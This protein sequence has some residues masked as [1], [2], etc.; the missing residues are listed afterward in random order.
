MQNQWRY[1]QVQNRG[2]IGIYLIFPYDSVVWFYLVT[3]KKQKIYTQ[4][5]HELFLASNSIF[6]IFFKFLDVLWVSQFQF[7]VM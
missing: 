5:T 6:Y 7:K 3:F 1:N 2:S 4:I